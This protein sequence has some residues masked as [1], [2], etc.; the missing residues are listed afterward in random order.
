MIDRSLDLDAER[1]IQAREGH[2]NTHRVKIRR[3]G[4]IN[5]Q[6]LQS[7]LDGTYQFDTT[8]LEAINFLDHLLRETPSSKLINIKRS[9]FAHEPVDRMLLGGCVEAMKG[10]YQS[11]RAAQVLQSLLPCPILTDN[12]SRAKNW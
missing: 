10:V 9:Y 7:Y 8:V 6:V 1:G 5:L 3:T 11:I 4:R 12:F 2:S